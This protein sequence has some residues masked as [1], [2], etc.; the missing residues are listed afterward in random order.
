LT[1]FKDTI[2]LLVG[3]VMIEK[4]SNAVSN[5]AYFVM[6]LTPSYIKSEWCK[7]ESQHY[8][9]RKLERGTGAILPILAGDCDIPEFIRIYKYLNL[10][11]QSIE[12]CC[13]EIFRRVSKDSYEIDERDHIRK[14]PDWVDRACEIASLARRSATHILRNE[15]E[16]WHHKQLHDHY[17]EVV[18]IRTH[19]SARLKMDW[20]S[21]L[22]ELQNSIYGFRGTSE[23]R[24]RIE[25]ARI[26][27]RDKAQRD[28]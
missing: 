4:L 18:E 1:T 28:F 23:D 2:D 10:Q 21:L 5:S 17:Y 25:R 15:D 3:D 26:A 14:Y 13:Q 7:Q 6:I 24:E 19:L 16:Q 20:D 27:I 9:T 8:L 22:E 11:S 12:Y